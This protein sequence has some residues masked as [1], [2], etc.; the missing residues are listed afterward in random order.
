MCNNV[1]KHDHL[2][3]REIFKKNICRCMRQKIYASK[4]EQFMRQRSISEKIYVHEE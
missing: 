3:D 1:S 2:K 4:N